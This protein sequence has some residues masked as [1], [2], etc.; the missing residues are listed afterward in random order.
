MA[1]RRRRRWWTDIIYEKDV[2]GS[3][4]PIGKIPFDKK[5]K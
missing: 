4:R 3:I 2:L 5:I 1:G